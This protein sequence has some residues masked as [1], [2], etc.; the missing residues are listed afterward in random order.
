MK[1]IEA[2]ETILNVLDDELVILANGMI[3]RESFITKDRLQNFYMLGSM[4]LA[5]SIG[6][7]IAI[8]QP[9]RKVVIFDGDGNLLMNLGT[10]ALTG[11]LLP[12]N[13][14][15]FVFDNEVYGS[16]GDQP[17]LTS[18]INLD[19]IAKASG[20]KMTLLIDNIEELQ[21]Q[22]VECLRSK[23]P[24]FVLVKISSECN[25]EIE[26]VSHSPVEIKERFM[27]VV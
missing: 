9:N 18:K 23:G 8:N 24:V 27:R 15:H 14:Y 21:T 19:K 3:C 4:G 13:F 5:P 1:R 26:R 6:L 10:L 7:G 22:T 2:I 20:Y 11:T 25:N 12:E 17:T 16:T